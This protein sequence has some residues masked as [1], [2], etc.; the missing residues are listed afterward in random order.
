MKTEKGFP[1]HSFPKQGLLPAVADTRA[2]YGGD[3]ALR[4]LSFIYI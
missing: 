3:A 1:L 2:G 4:L